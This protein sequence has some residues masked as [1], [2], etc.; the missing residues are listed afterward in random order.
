MR[1][2]TDCDRYTKKQERVK[3]KAPQSL[4]TSESGGKPVR[5]V[6][7]GDHI[8]PSMHPAQDPLLLALRAANIFGI[9]AEMKM[10]ACADDDCENSM[11]DIMAEEGICRG[12]RKVLEAKNMG[13]LSKRPGSAERI[14]CIHC[15]TR[16]VLGSAIRFKRM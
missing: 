6:T 7:F 15:R 9:M 3:C 2:P 5:L 13:R 4:H 10:L 11:G 14:L 16:Q 12:K 8:E 1:L